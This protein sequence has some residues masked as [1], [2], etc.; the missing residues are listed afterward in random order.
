MAGQ[1]ND[2]FKSCLVENSIIFKLNLV[3][4]FPSHAYGRIDDLKETIMNPANC[5]SSIVKHSIKQNINFAHPET[6][7][8]YTDIIKP[9]LVGDA[10]MRLLSPLLFTTA[11]GYHRFDYSLY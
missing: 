11:K 2:S 7:Y 9:N 4:D 3:S 6:I 8:V 1:R 5:P 10:F